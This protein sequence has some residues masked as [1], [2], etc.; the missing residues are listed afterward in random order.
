MQQYVWENS[1]A[2]QE[3]FLEEDELG[4]RERV[5]EMPRSACGPSD[6]VDDEPTFLGPDDRYACQTSP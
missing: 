1:Y 2:H 4:L 3:E 5:S 6:V